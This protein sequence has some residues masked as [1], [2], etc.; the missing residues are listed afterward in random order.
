MKVDD[1]PITLTWEEIVALMGLIRDRVGDV[2]INCIQY[3]IHANII[4]N[5][6]AK[7]STGKDLIVK[8]WQEYN[9]DD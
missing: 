8:G 6:Y 4:G 2:D 5:A 7:L 9:D 1:T 3:D